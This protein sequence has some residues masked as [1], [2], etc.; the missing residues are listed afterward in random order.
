MPIQAEE[1]AL[2][3][4]GALRGG[5]VLPMRAGMEDVDVARSDAAR[6]TRLRRLFRAVTPGRGPEPDSGPS[7]VAVSS[8]APSGTGGTAETPPSGSPPTGR[9]RDVRSAPDEPASP[10]ETVSAAA[11]E[12]TAARAHAAHTRRQVEQAEREAA[13]QQRAFRALIN[14][15]YPSVAPDI[16]VLTTRP[17][18]DVVDQWLGVARLLSDDFHHRSRGLDAEARERAMHAAVSD[19]LEAQARSSARIAGYHESELDNEWQPDPAFAGQTVWEHYLCREAVLVRDNLHGEALGN[20]LAALGELWAAA[21][22]LLERSDDA[23]S[24][25]VLDVRV[26]RPALPSPNA[27]V[28]DA[29][30]APSSRPSTDTRP[31]RADSASDTPNGSEHFSANGGSDADNRTEALRDVVI[32]ELVSDPD[33]TTAEATEV[34]EVTSARDGGDGPPRPPELARA[35]VDPLEA[36]QVRLRAALKVVEELALW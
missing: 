14:E 7:T 13:R 24:F 19:A 8:G 16:E 36:A 6:P 22:E 27:T 25:R 4:L 29:G 1:S 20:W 5:L 11:R 35:A 2:E 17:P 9:T 31:E 34:G 21:N 15:T 18:M 33:P 32:P 30:I 12:L 26:A 3:A 10:A 23:R 28:V